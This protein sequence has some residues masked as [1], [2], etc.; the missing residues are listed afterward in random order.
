[1]KKPLFLLILILFSISVFDTGIIGSTVSLHKDHLNTLDTL[2]DKIH[3]TVK[4]IFY[5]LP[6]EKSRL[7]LREVIL[8]DKRFFSTDTIFNNYQ[9]SSFFKGN[10]I[11]KGLMESKPDSIQILLALGNTSLTIEKGGEADFKNI[12]LLNC[13]Y[14][15]SSKE[16]VDKEY[17][18]LLHRLYPILT[19]STSEKSLSPYSIGKESGQMIIVGKLFE[20][21][22]PYFRIGISSITMLPTNNSKSVFVLD[23]VFSKEDE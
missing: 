19:D 4:Q 10:A 22:K 16:S 13:K 20:S 5:N 18:K 12:M 2:T 3:P 23:I 1:M 9:P 7:E 17:E 8:N 14:F 15:Y 11:D 21:F 6:L